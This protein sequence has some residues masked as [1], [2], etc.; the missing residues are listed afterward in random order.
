MPLIIMV[1][2]P[3]AGKTTRARAIQRYLQEEKKLDVQLINEESLGFNKAEYYKDAQ[4]E[5]IL[6]GSLKSNVEKFIDQQRVVIIDSLNY[7][8]GYRYELYCLARNAQTNIVVVFCDTDPEIAMK[9]SQ[10]GG[11][12][13]PF[14]PELI[15]DYIGRLERPNPAARWD[16]PMI[17]LRFDE[18]IP[19]EDLAKTVLEGKK[20]RD[21]VSTKPV[22]LGSNYYQIKINILSFLLLII[23]EISFDANF[24]YELDKTC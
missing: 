19:F 10:E 23:Q 7:I 20:P 9:I 15:K 3:C 1:G 5:K 13:N 12:E 22:S 6:R 11:Y 17:H 21:P 18:E 14:P 24:I 8:K 16:S 4:S 2:V